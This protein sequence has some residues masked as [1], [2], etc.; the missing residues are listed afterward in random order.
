[1]TDD[2]TLADQ[3][4]EAARAGDTATAELHLRELVAKDTTEPIVYSRLAAICQW[5]GR[6]EEALLM[7][8]IALILSPDN[9]TF[10]FNLGVI[11]GQ[12]PDL[13]NGIAA[14]RRA[15]EIKPDYPEAEY[16]LGTLLFQAGEYSEGW[17]CFDNARF[18]IPSAAMPYVA[19]Q[20]PLWSPDHAH[21][22]LLVIGEQ[23]LGDSLQFLR[24]APV[25]AEQAGVITICVQENLA[26]LARASE[27]ADTV[28]TPSTAVD[29]EPMPWL[30]L[31]SLPQILGVTPQ[32]P[33]T[34]APYLKIPE[35]ALNTWKNH[36]S[37]ARSPLVGLNWQGNPLAEANSNLNGRSIPLNEFQ[38]LME[39]EGIRFVSLQKG[40]GSEQVK[41]C[42]FTE[43]F[44]PEQELIDEAWDF[45]E[46]GAIVSTC[47][48]VITSDTVTAHLAGALGKPVWL[49]LAYVP[50]W[51]WG[52]QG[53]QTFWY[54]TM[55]LFR[56]RQRGDWGE[57][58]KRVSTALSQMWRTP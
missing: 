22:S 10:L 37:S 35:P 26:E 29:L 38:P 36:L 27:L 25:I 23:G 32:N 24:Y 46:T 58:I 6:L 34:T 12:L 50:D 47:D 17:Q 9:P 52:L 13:G 1:M 43:R 44:I 53:D 3:A 11:L 14:Y 5:T 48:L 49:L 33:I 21:H 20:G 4:M 51:R 55:R 39:I 57:V 7:I 56:Q 18:R 45:I 40:P 31:L 42:G 8:Q 28:V 16:N 19:G 2:R 54:P 30:P 41:A 15:L